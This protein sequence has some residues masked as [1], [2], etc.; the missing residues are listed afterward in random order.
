[1]WGGEEIIRAL[2]KERG[3]PL[4]E[5]AVERMNFLGSEREETWEEGSGRPRLLGLLLSVQQI[6]IVFLLCGR[7]YKI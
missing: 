1:M 4:G 3:G 2:R 5:W 7:R 6:F